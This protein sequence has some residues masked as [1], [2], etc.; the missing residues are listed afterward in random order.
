MIAQ[1]REIADSYE[2]RLKIQGLLTEWLNIRQIAKR[3]GKSER[4]ARRVIMRMQELNE[5]ETK[6]VGCTN[7]YKLKV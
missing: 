4:S 7:Y 5:V 1:Q 6:V 2:T 3:I